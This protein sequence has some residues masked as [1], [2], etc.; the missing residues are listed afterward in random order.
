MNKSSD[1][2]LWIKVIYRFFQTP[3]T[4]YIHSGIASLHKN[5]DKLQNEYELKNENGLNYEIN[6]KNE[7]I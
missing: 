5:E 3:T 1:Q 6:L 4:Q 2:R 7:T